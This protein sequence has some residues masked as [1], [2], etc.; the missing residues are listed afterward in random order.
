SARSAMSRAI[1]RIGADTSSSARSS[2]WRRTGEGHSEMGTIAS[3]RPAEHGAIRFSARWSLAWV[4]ASL[5]LS[6]CLAQQ[7]DLAQVKRDEELGKVAARLDAVAATLGTLAKTLD[8]RME[9]HDKAISAG[10]ARTGAVEKKLDAQLTQFGKSLADFKLA[11]NALGEKLV[12]ED[13]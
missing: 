10:D 1:S 9:E 4:L 3:I 13:H 5:L 12:Q 6:G 7:A 11:M 8:A 2:V